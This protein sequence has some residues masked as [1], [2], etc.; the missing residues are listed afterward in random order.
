MGKP[1]AGSCFVKT[2]GAALSL[3]MDGTLDI[4]MSDVVRTA[5]LSTAGVVGYSETP[6]APSISGDFYVD[7]DFPLK[8]LCQNTAMTVIAELA[9]GRTYTL[10][11]AFV[12]GETNISAKDG[13]V[14]LK[15]VGTKGIWD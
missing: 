14:S 1:I 5:E 15:F 2:D 3:K 8:T 11:N 10:S 7:S 6:V 4:T 12:E 9:N 13:T